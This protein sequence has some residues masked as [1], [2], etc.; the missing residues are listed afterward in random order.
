[1]GLILKETASLR[2]S[3]RQRRSTFGFNTSY[4]VQLAIL[5]VL[6]F[7]T[8]EVTLEVG[9]TKL[10]MRAQSETAYKPNKSQLSAINVADGPALVVA[11]AGTG[12]TSVIVERIVRLIEG[13]ADPYSIVALTF[14]EKAAQ[15]MLDRLNQLRGGYTFDVTI[16]TY[17]AFGE[18]LLK[19]YATDIGMHSGLTLLGDVAKLIFLRDNLEAL[20]L[21]YYAPVTQP[22]RLLGDIAD[23]FS[24]LKQQ[25]V[26]EEKY[27][28]F[29]ENLPETDQASRLEKARHKELAQAF[30][31][32]R[33][34][35][36]Q[37]NF[38]DYDDQIYL[39]LEL[40]N[41]RPNVI[42]RL[43]ERFSYLLVDEFQDTN[44]MQS[45]LLDALTGEPANIM[46][47]GDDDQSIYAFRGATVENILSF[48]DRY[49]KAKEV[50]LTENYRSSQAILDAAY[51]LI[52]HNNPH[53]LEAQ[54]GL[55][56]RLVSQQG[57]GSPPVI[58]QFKEREQEI[59]WISEDIKRRTEAG[60]HPGSIAV[61]GR[62]NQTIQTL[63]TAL[64]AANIEHSVAGQTHDL[65]REPVIKAI[66]ETLKTIVDPLDNKSLFHA[67]GS[68]VFDQTDAN[69]L[70]NLA[71][72]SR[73]SHQPLSQ[74]ILTSDIEPLKSGLDLISSWRE[75]AGSLSVGQLTYRII[76]DSGLKDR[77]VASAEA[78]P[79]A[80]QA[81]LYLAQLFNSMQEFERIAQ[82][83][84]AQAYIESLELLSST[85][86]AVSDDLTSL[87]SEQAVAVMTIHKAKGLEWDTVY[88]VDLV[89]Q[90][91]PMQ[92]RGKSMEVPSELAA[93]VADAGEPMREERRLMYV[94][95]TRAK[96]ELILSYATGSGQRPRKASRFIGEIS[97]DDHPATTE[98][99]QPKKLLEL[100][101]SPDLPVN[102]L[103]SRMQDGEYLSLSVSQVNDYQR[104][105]Y[106]FYY[107]HVLQVPTELSPTLTY[108]SAIHNAIEAYHQ[109]RLNGNT[110]LTYRQLSEQLEANW[111]KAGFD[112]I[113]H[114][115]Q[116][117]KSA[118]A[119]L[120]NFI[121][122]EEQENRPP[123]RVE[124]PF[125]IKLNEAKL[126][127]R[128]RFDTVYEDGD[129]VEIR[130]YKTGETV[131]DEKKAKSRSQ[132]S[133]QLKLY[134]LAWQH[135][136]GELPAKLTL[137][138][139]ETGFIGTSAK[140]QQSID[141]LERKLS[142]M[143][144]SIRAFEFPPGHDH[145]YCQHDEL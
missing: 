145:R 99:D 9:Y 130:D 75:Q 39:L 44:P 41:T 70:S 31:A 54:H 24:E 82:R 3:L 4:R 97:D 55:N 68:Q 15:E 23:Y 65:Y 126:I 79:A 36:R 57:T 45:A 26:T 139:I 73:R 77:L 81:V 138:F 115:D 22:D 40:L 12:K 78:D 101:S 58:K 131:T 122:R 95:M 66:H 38:I 32:Y 18:M 98:T 8:Q 83:T 48:K 109:S 114:R 17:N 133:D 102:Q 14:T 116:A 30:S 46:V 104:C 2:V 76:E 110:P 42:K 120:K 49:P 1:M 125:V 34:L 35:S 134:A 113:N 119:T 84:S 19:Q 52:Q 47:V 142:H 28:K 71:A 88:I 25:L 96:E 74:E 124:A 103:P 59:S 33:Q 111:P 21:D 118:K 135:M 37:H 132:S 72:Q 93:V 27:H 90:S 5:Y 63:H 107:R 69:Q 20:K 62:R 94:A 106:D 127:I 11:G 10:K 29:I 121:E 85:G 112:S 50:V 51:R 64:D 108:G 89:E 13:G 129:G 56:K 128:G 100:Y 67:L 80:H 7:K 91:F 140:R 143:A 43:R 86:E 141:T 105:P 92:A 53:R 136:H 60:Q 6:K 144:D 16:M 117:L 137:D 87:I 61:L 123:S